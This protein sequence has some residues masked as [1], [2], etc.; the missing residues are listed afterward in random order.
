MDS[1]PTTTQPTAESRPQDE[2][3]RE[4]HHDEEKLRH[5]AGE[6]ERKIG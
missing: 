3:D 6:D 5:E 2:D 4:G 1:L